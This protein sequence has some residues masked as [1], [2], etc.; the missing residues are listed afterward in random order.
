MNWKQFLK[1]DWRKI[2]I[3]IVLSACF[4]FWILYNTS[5][6][7]PRDLRESCCIQNVYD[8]EICQKIIS[9]ESELYRLK[10]YR[11]KTPE[12]ICQEYKSS[13][14]KIIVLSMELLTGFLILIK[15]IIPYLLSCLTVWIYDTLRKKKK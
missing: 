15:F 14:I 1:P 7:P 11:N 2:V 5:P 8:R 9:G 6:G 13:G 4:S 12:E 3:F 10:P